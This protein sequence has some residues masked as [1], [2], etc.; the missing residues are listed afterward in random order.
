MLSPTPA[1]RIWRQWSKTSWAS[2]QPNC[3]SPS[4]V[5]FS[6]WALSMTAESNMSPRF[7]LS[8]WVLPLPLLLQK[9]CRSSSRKSQKGQQLSMLSLSYQFWTWKIR[10][11]TS[12]ASPRPNRSSF[13]AVKFSQK[14]LS[15]A[16][17]LHMSPR[18]TWLYSHLLLPI[19]I[20]ISIP[21][22][23]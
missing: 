23:L 13:L 7:T 16:A 8:F 11:T 18:S 15:R 21:F 19:F 6:Q 4:L 5:K 3:S 22:P 1:L 10:S 20:P 2:P 14:V 17:M 9:S 12:W